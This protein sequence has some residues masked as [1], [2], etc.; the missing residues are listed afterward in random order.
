MKILLSLVYNLPLILQALDDLCFQL[1]TN[2][3]I[4]NMGSA[5]LG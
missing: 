3:L 4:P 2:Y 1:N 5:I